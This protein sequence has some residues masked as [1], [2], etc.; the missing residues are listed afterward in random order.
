MLKKKSVKNKKRKNNLENGNSYLAPSRA[1]LFF[2]SSDAVF[3]PCDSVTGTIDHRFKRIS[4]AATENP[5]SYGYITIT[6]I[7]LGI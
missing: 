2:V 4:V 1:G 7:S 6:T 3:E 5:K